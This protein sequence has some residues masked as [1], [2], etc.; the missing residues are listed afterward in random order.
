MTNPIVNFAE[1]DEFVWRGAEPGINGLDWLVNAG[2]KTVINLEWE[3]SDPA[4]AGL[5]E[6]KLPD[7]EPLPSIAPGIEDGHIK[8]LLTTIRTCAKPVFIHCRSGENRTG[9][10][11]AAYRLI[12]RNDPVDD[13]IADLVRYHGLWASA[14]LNYV[15]GL[16]ARRTEF[17]AVDNA[18]D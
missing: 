1:V 18:G 10:A 14:D 4:L 15:R 12:E 2:C 9:V 11:V 6:I 8:R 13:V 16:M 7:F 5:V 17:E 3:A